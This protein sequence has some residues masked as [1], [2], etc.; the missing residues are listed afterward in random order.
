MTKKNIS[1][2]NKLNIL[3]KF[4]ILFTIVLAIASLTFLFYSNNK[5]QNKLDKERIYLNIIS[6][7]SEYVT[8]I[9]ETKLYKLENDNYVESGI[10]NKKVNIKLAPLDITSDTL[11][12]PLADMDYYISYKDVVKADKEETNTRYKEYIPFNKNIKTK[13]PTNFYDKDNNLIMTINDTF[14]FPIIIND[15][16][17]FG[18]SYLDKLYYIKNEDVLAT[19]KTKNTSVET[20]TNI[21]TFAYHTVYKKG[22]EKCTNMYVCH[23]IEQFDSH[24]KYL[25]DNNY[26]TLTM[27]E[28]EMFLDGKIRIPK[29]T[30]VITLD[31]GRRLYNSVP[32]VEKYQINSTFF[33]IASLTNNKLKDYLGKTTYAK[34]ESHTYDMH[35]NWQCS[36][37]TQ[38]SQLLCEKNDKIIA[39]IEKSREILGGTSY[40]FAY[41]FY[42]YNE[43]LI[44]IIK[45][46]DFH[47]AFVG[48][49]D[50]N[51]FSDSKT[52]KYKVRR[53][54]IWGDCNLDEFKTYINE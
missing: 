28:L 44:N 6:K 48:V 32:I 53:L 50:S 41:P 23:T 46:L 38:G 5:Y 43:N 10:L 39:D 18:I 19:E 54:T 26:L 2:K 35:N 37:G 22:S 16:D 51:G 11:Y 29:K 13:S 3:T 4:I 36:G 7:Y 17:R 47:L 1:S 8:T 42:D 9:K 52:D 12:F 45:K 21:R 15:T 30:V 24:M 25:H 20:R 49:A 33:V 14:N 40:Y 31:D 34:F 27:E